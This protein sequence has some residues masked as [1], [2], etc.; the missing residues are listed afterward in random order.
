MQPFSTK[1]NSQSLPPLRASACVTTARAR[2]RA[3][4]ISR[5]AALRYLVHLPASLARASLAPPASSME[6]E[7]YS[8]LQIDTPHHEKTEEFGGPGGGININDPGYEQSSHNPY[9]FR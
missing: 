3:G 8:K 1:T 4:C 5:E 6:A 7:Q 2:A 9:I